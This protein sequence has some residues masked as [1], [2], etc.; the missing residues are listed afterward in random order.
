M[1][2]EVEKRWVRWRGRGIVVDLSEVWE[3]LVR[4]EI[5]GRRCICAAARCE[6]VSTRVQQYE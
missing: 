1:L 2:G 6:L 5:R 4:G 3:R